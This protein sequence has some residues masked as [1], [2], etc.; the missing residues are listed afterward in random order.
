MA[1]PKHRNTK[2]RQGKRR[3]NLFLKEPSFSLCPKCKSAVLPHRVCKFCG[4][5]KGR[6]IIDV[7]KKLKKKE[8]KQREKEIKETEKQE[9]KQQKEKPMTL[10]E[11]SKKKF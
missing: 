2:S 6:E 7:M 10:E 1:V 9:Q 5:Y 8:K 4:F 3:A 11:L